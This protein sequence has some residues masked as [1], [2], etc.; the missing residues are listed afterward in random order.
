MQSKAP[1]LKA[2][3]DR[4]HAAQESARQLIEAAPRFDEPAHHAAGYHALIEAQAM[5]YNWIVAPRLDHPRIFTHTSWATYLFTLAG[6]CPDF[7]YGILP[8]DGRGT[9]RLRGRHGDVRLLLVQV[10][11]K[12]MGVDGSRCTG[13]YEFSRADTGDDE[14]EIVLSATE[15]PGNWIPLDAGSDFNL[16]ILRR[17]MLDWGDDP[18]TLEIET[19]DVPDGLGE[20]D[21]TATAHRIT[22]AADFQLAV[23]RNWAVGLY[24]FS[25]QLTGGHFN[26]WGP[27]P[28]ELMAAIAGSASCNYA[29]LL[30]DLQPD[31]ALLVE[32]E[33]PVGSAYWSLQIVDVWSKSLDF[34]HA[35]TDVNMKHAHVDADGKV[36][37]VINADDP[38]VPNWLDPRGRRQGL[39]AI[40]NYRSQHFAN[41]TARVVRTDALRAQLPDDTPQ[42]SQ[43]QRRVAV[44]HRR[45]AILKLYGG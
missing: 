44:A 34:M 23:I 14:I 7:I 3:W 18:G 4:F 9:Y 38:G 27:V 11:N 1:G 43:A 8:L 40:R 24:D 17:L 13:N 37:A 19:V 41:P 32:L 15:Q 20:L 22:M 45:P 10:L 16:L 33:E 25:M 26:V 2:A 29:F 30:F 31:E 28:G 35:Q 12:P 39:L 21:D 42:I 6:N 36:R 5:A